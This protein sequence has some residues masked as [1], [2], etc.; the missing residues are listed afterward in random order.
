M[1]EQPYG[2][3]SHPGG[4]TALRALLDGGATGACS[5]NGDSWATRPTAAQEQ[6][7]RRP[8][9]Q[10]P[11]AGMAVLDSAAQSAARSADALRVDAVRQKIRATRAQIPNPPVSPGLPSLP[12]TPTPMQPPAEA[13]PAAATPTTGRGTRRRR[14]AE[15]FFR[16]EDPDQLNRSFLMEY[17]APRGSPYH[18]AM[19]WVSA[20]FESQCKFKEAEK[21]I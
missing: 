19:S 11:P 6:A 16:V 1:R 9:A 4:G 15:P 20:R 17:P 5:G 8:G 13:A 18:N 10:L 21:V 3:P 7:E 14:D 12:S 2:S